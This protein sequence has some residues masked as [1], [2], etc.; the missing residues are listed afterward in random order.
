MNGYY[1]VPP[2]VLEDADEMAA[3]AREAIAVAL[4]APRKPKRA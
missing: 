4:R 2:S 3:W 1:Q